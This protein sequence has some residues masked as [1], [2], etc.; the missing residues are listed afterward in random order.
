MVGTQIRTIEQ[1]AEYLTENVDE[2]DEVVKNGYNIIVKTGQKPAP[3][4]EEA[5]TDLV[6]D[7]N[8]C[9]STAFYYPD[10]DHKPHLKYS[11]ERL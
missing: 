4:T 10:D 9:C 2:S 1:A 3:K 6:S 8:F 7:G 11:I 5:V